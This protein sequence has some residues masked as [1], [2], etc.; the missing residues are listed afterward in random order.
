LTDQ[1]KTVDLT[2]LPLAGE[3]IY[4][5]VA[6]LEAAA[7][8][9]VISR[10]DGTIIWTNQAFEQLS[11][12][13]REEALGRNTNLLK[14]GEQAPEFYREMWNT[15]LSGQ[16][17][18]GELRNRRKDGS[19]YQEEMTITPVRNAA[20][21]I[22]HFIAIKLDITERKQA[23][24]SLRGSEERF[25]LF[26]EHAPAALA[27][28]DRH[29]RYLHVSQRW[30]SD[31]VLGE[32][33]LRGV[34]H[35]EVFPEISDRWK[36]AHRRGLAGEAFQNGDD[37]FERADGSVQ[38]IRW[39]VRPWHDSKGEVGGIVIFTE[40]ITEH[41]QAEEA[42]RASEAYYRSILGCAFDFI[43]VSDAQGNFE[44][45]NEATCQS[46]GWTSEELLTMKVPDILAPEERPR[47]IQMIKSLN[48]GALSRGEWT[49]LRKDG[50][51]FLSEVGVNVLPNGHLLGIGRDITERKQAEAAVQE[52]RAMLDAAMASMTDA[53]FIS[54]A[55][56]QFVQFNDAFATFH[57]FKNKAEC[58]DNIASYHELL[59]VFMPDGRL[60]PKEE[61]AVPRALRGET[62]RNAEFRL[63]RKDTGETWIASYSFSPIRDSEG[64]IVGAVV[65]A[66]DITDTKKVEA[67][68]RKSEERLQLAIELADIGEWERDLKTQIVTCSRG[69]DRIFGFQ[70][71]GYEWSFKIFLEHVLPEDRFKVEEGVK[72]VPAGE[73]WD[74]EVR[75]RREDGEIRWIWSRGRQFLDET[76]E[77]DRMVGTII[78]ITERK[79]DGEIRKALLEI[80]QAADHAQTLDVLYKRVHEIIK[81]IVPADSFYIA[82]YDEKKDELN[83]PYYVD[84][85]D[86]PI[87][88]RKSGRGRTEY[89]LRTGKPLRLDQ[90]TE[91]GMQQRGEIVAIGK[92]TALWVGVPLKIDD[93]TIGVMAVQ[94]YTDPKAFNDTHLQILMNV[95]SH[96]AKVIARKRAEADR[97]TA[98]EL[99]NKA[100]HASPVG[101]GISS[102]SDGVFLDVNDALSKETEYA[103]GELIGKSAEILYV[104]PEDRTRL[105]EL[106]RSRV[107]VRDFKFQIKTK[108]GKIR[109]VRIAAERLEI[110]GVAC[111]LVLVMDTTE[112]ELLEQQL[113]QAQRME[114][115]GNLAGG[116]AHDF[117]NMLGVIIGNME[118]MSERVPPDEIFQNYMEKVRLAVR[119]A[120]SVTRQLLAFSRK[121]ILQPAVLDLNTSV[122]QLTKMTQ[123]LIGE[124]VRVVLTLS[125]DLASVKADPGQ[126]EQVLMN[127]VV[128]ARDAMPDGGTLNI[129]T[130]NAEMD[131]E[132]ENHHVGSKVGKYVK[133]SVSDTGMGMSREVMARVFEP[134]FTT[135]EVGKGTG[136]GLATVYGIV[137]QSEGYIWVESE[138]GAGTT[139]DIYLPRV[140]SKPTK[141]RTRKLPPSSWGSETLLLVEDEKSL[142]DVTRIQLEKLGY[143]VHEA[144]DAERAI[145]VFNEHAQ[146]IVMLITDVI[147]PGMNGRVLADTLKAK[148]PGLHVLFI[149]GYTDDKVLRGSVSDLKQAILIK[150]YTNEIMATRLR[151]ILDGK[152]HESTGL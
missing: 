66:R 32:R 41:H 2:E 17:W 132:F 42:L 28:F 75:I 131:Q 67:D 113:R 83:F 53:V 88:Q 64:E 25:R 79:L 29:M 3:L 9:I 106:I 20:G 111:I 149:T 47:L 48:P 76:G 125:P 30:R 70:S 114:A 38:W 141:E 54:D 140:E 11:G 73:T 147:M 110:D 57:K 123:R 118:L 46:I 102:L 6:A 104:N 95:S 31:Y 74:F 63:R 130:A 98:E 71:P 150:P 5:Q 151:E 120:T 137:K 50:S 92:A 56:G 128:N 138:P 107:A 105:Q 94:H 96:V 62:A 34:S 33:E 93:R 49:S 59:D 24:A 146:E 144:E 100:F 145:V 86:D 115:I 36:E 117:N 135:K 39:E 7:N 52:S 19:L 65:V 21:E 134:F 37:R 116:V 84:D 12:Y 121:Q 78:D 44:Y 89:V 13:K 77:P 8:A 124:N 129:K 23:E 26:I 80:I 72:A 14:S 81:S 99:F 45:V 91:K 126:M 122:Q 35:Y 90:E 60:R 22:S 112:H 109:N 139:F 87:T 136:L 15:V 133:L 16:K 27:M 85:T 108:S 10:R 143:R 69:H 103:S 152:P 61:W 101:I 4:L 58:A 119:S 18:R 97:R 142:R 127:L 148:K 68:L 40:D 1:A 82:L 43:T 51:T 55:K